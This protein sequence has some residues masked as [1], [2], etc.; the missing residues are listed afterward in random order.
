MEKW[1]CY[2]TISKDYPLNFVKETWIEQNPEYWFNSV[3]DGLKEIIIG[4][5]KSILALS[6]SGQMH[7]LVH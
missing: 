6:F 4:Y 7:G 2:K 5:E 3:Y 1:E